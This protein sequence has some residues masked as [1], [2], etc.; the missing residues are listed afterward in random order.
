MGVETA[1]AI[2]AV[3]G[4]LMI[5]LGNEAGTQLGCSNVEVLDGSGWRSEAGRQYWVL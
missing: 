5:V 2:Q 1:V 3:E 4:V